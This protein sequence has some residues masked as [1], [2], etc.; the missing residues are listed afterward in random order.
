MIVLMG[1]T[2]SG[3]DSALNYLVKNHGFKKVITYTT[4]PM[5][6]GEEQ[7]KTYHF[8]S[9]AEF[10]G[11]INLGEFAEWKSYH[12]NNGIWYYGTAKSDLEN[13]DDKSAIILTPAGYEEIAG[14]LTRSKSKPY[15]VYL[16]A[17]IDNSAAVSSA[18]RRYRGSRKESRAR[19]NGLQRCI[20]YREWCD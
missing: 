9:Q 14:Y 7:D 19:R 2:G 15:A 10:Q 4:R 8:V 11:K 20:G 1:K 12:T 13:A 17:D 3:K 5:R 18:R 16:Y 6:D